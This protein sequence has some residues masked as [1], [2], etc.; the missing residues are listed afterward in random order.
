MSL[1]LAKKELECKDGTCQRREDLSC[2]LKTEDIIKEIA[3]AFTGAASVVLWQMDAVRWGR[4]QSGQLTMADGEPLEAVY[5]QEIRVFDE[6]E[7][8]HLVRQGNRFSGRLVQDGAGEA[9]SYVDSLARLWGE[10]TAAADGFVQLQDK[11]R[12][13]LL[14]VPCTEEAACYGLV[15]RN[16][17]GYAEKTGQAGYTDYRFVKIT[18]TDGGR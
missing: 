8:L 14:T 13:L 6:Q 15:T 16:Y 17:I 10:R 18:A 1:D 5:L 12:K 2:C 11:A 3:D 7:E 9:C 4:W